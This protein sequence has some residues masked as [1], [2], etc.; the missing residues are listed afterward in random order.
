MCGI[1]EVNKLDDKSCSDKSINRRKN[2]SRYDVKGLSFCPAQKK[3][4]FRQDA[5]NL[6]HREIHK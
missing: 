1:I 2:R 6:L 5:P 4:G 3:T